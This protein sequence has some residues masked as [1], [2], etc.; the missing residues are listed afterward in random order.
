MVS[1]SREGESWGNE[2]PE[3]SWF[4]A[5]EGKQ[6]GPYP[7]AQFR[8]FIA[9]RMV[10]A[11]TLVWTEGMSGWQKAGDVPG[12]IA[13]AGSPPTLPGSTG[14]VMSGGDHGGGSL[15]IDLE[16][17][18]FV[19]RCLVCFLGLIT[20]IAAPWAIVWYAKWLVSRVQV[21]GRPNL[22][23]T[24]SALTIAAWYFG[25][26]V[27][28]II[29][30][31]IESQTLGDLLSI[32]QIALYW[33][34]LR[35]F[36][37]NLASNG[38]PL[39]LSFSGSLW[40]YLGWSLLMVFS[41]I[42]I[43]GWAWVYTAQMRWICR[44]IQGTRRQVVPRRRPGI[45]LARHRRPAL[46]LADHSDPLGGALAAE[47]ATV[48]NRAGGAARLCKRVNG[49]TA[50]RAQSLPARRRRSACRQA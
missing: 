23:F 39:G 20:V 11:E 14:A 2:M 42:T 41:V 50:F 15:S 18:E 1:A 33:L 4:F 22:S 27:L 5:A 21:P 46:G 25:F 48:A 12:L 30:A 35:W 3:R 13:S 24:G 43:I 28:A 32:V 17:W 9:R 31:M 29:V 38:Q 26:I 36:I 44:N 45:S 37:A 8:G 49:F 40:A 6:Q 10:Q 7:D 34:F 47:L 19:W 16:I